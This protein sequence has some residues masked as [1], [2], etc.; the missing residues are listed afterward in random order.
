MKN[1]ASKKKSRVKDTSYYTVYQWMKSRLGLRKTNLQ[2]FAIIYAFSRDNVGEYN[3]GRAY[4]AELADVSLNSV[5]NACTY[6]TDKNYIIQGERFVESGIIKTYAVNAELVGGLI[7]NA[8]LQNLNPPAIFEPPVVQNLNHPRSSKFEPPVVQNLNPILK[9]NNK[10]INIEIDTQTST[11]G[12]TP[13]T[14]QNFLPIQSVNNS[15]PKGLS[16]NSPSKVAD[17]SKKTILNKKEYVS[18]LMG[19]GVQQDL[20][21]EFFDL[22]KSKKQVTSARTV[23]VLSNQ[24]NKLNVPLNE[25]IEFLLD[26]GWAKFDP[27]WDTRYNPNSKAANTARRD[28]ERNR[29]KAAEQIFAQADAVKKA[30]NA[31]KPLSEQTYVKKG[32]MYNGL[33]EVLV[34]LT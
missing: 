28:N 19:L 9:E 27:T 23:K 5:R 6:L 24:C 33:G 25:M 15:I 16:K 13:K 31:A 10:S 30:E 26:K 32:I 21:I 22:K 20:S 14:P 8:P 3:G 4:M 1:Q 29:A 34:D 18:L 11:A 2:I 12:P 7:E 17:V